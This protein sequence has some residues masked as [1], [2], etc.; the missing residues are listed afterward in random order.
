M[1]DINNYNRVEIY[2]FLINVFLSLLSLTVKYLLKKLI[3]HNG[4]K[5][6][7]ILMKEK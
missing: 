1:I 6:N 4:R 2:I 3:Q 5:F 7:Q